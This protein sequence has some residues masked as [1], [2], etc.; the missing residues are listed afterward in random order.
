MNLKD[1]IGDA[2]FECV[3]PGGVLWHWVDD[4]RRKTM[5]DIAFMPK[6]AV[7][8]IQFVDYQLDGDVLRGVVM[9]T[10]EAPKPEQC[11]IITN[12]SLPEEL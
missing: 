12:V 4:E 10:V 5:S 2:G 9:V 1:V 6:L 3:R 11:A 8:D 7:R